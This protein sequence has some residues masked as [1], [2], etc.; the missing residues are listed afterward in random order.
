MLRVV[1]GS[2]SG[3]ARRSLLVGFLPA[4][5]AVLAVSLAVVT[6]ANPPRKA[7]APTPRSTGTAPSRAAPPP[8]RQSPESTRHP[9]VAAITKCGDGLVPSPYLSRERVVDVAVEHATTD[10]AYRGALTRPHNIRAEFMTASEVWDRL[11]FRG[12]PGHM[13]REAAKRS[14]WLVTVEGESTTDPSSEMPRQVSAY[15][16]LYV[17]T[18][19]PITGK[20]SLA[21]I[22]KDPPWQPIAREDT[23]ASDPPRCIARPGGV[24]PDSFVL[25]I[26]GKT[27]IIGRNSDLYPRYS[28]LVRDVLAHLKPK[29]ASRECAQPEVDRLKEGM[30]GLE[31]LYPEPG[32][33]DRGVGRYTRAFISTEPPAPGLVPPDVFL[34][35]KGSYSIHVP[36]EAAGEVERL[37]QLMGVRHIE[38]TA[39]P[40]ISPQPTAAPRPEGSPGIPPDQVAIYNFLQAVS[41]G[42]EARMRSYLSP[43]YDDPIPTGQTAYAI[44]WQLEEASEGPY[45]PPGYGFHAPGTE[46]RSSY[47]Y[48]VEYIDREHCP[49]REM[50][51]SLTVELRE[52]K[53]RISRLETKPR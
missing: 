25:Y 44:H 28:A 34:G 26:R 6:L 18:V 1:F 20:A 43:D 29:W 45:S 33:L 35:A 8:A 46:D 36:A 38:P 37:R 13:L 12:G 4:V 23:S 2:L 16:A 11:A 22:W 14:L 9:D 42:E 53:W 17:L 47:T 19:D 51:A 40:A 48:E 52:G 24:A 5:L 3:R 10:H 50:H 15:H 49:D 32:V 39:R 27:T 41:F 30:T 31:V 7:L 21:T